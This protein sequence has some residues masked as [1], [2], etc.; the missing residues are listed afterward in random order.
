MTGLAGDT[1][2]T[3]R[4]QLFEGEAWLHV[5]RAGA[6]DGMALQAKLV[7]LAIEVCLPDLD[8]LAVDGIDHCVGMHR[9][10]PLG[11]VVFVAPAAGS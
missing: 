10:A 8:E 11:V 2:E 5:T 1:F 7:L 3:H 6:G 9:L 4:T